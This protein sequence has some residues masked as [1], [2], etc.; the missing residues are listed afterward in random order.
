MCITTDICRRVKIFLIYYI[1]FYITSTSICARRGKKS[2]GYD[3][4]DVKG[5]G[6]RKLM[7]HGN[8]SE[9]TFDLKLSLAHESIEI[10]T[11]IN[12]LH[13]GWWEKSSNNSAKMKIKGFYAIIVISWHTWLF[14]K[15]VIFQIFQK[16]SSMSWIY[17]FCRN[18]SFCIKPFIFLYVVHWVMIDVF[19]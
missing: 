9:I 15:Y 2:S 10:C 17:F 12:E 14:L 1:F 13:H 5:G 7:S 19:F 18:Y 8:W 3:E 6:R 4:W 16:K 11:K